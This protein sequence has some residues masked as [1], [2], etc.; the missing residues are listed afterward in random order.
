MYRRIKD[1][2]FQLGATQVRLAWHDAGTYDV[3]INQW[4]KAGGANGKIRFSP[5]IQHGAN[6]GVALLITLRVCA[7]V[8]KCAR[9]WAWVRVRACK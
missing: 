6:A 7:C 1:I 9:A 5:E 4:P 8:R 3:N 2:I